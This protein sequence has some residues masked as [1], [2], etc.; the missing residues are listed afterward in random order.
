MASCASQTQRTEASSAPGGRPGTAG[1][2]VTYDAVCDRVEREFLDAGLLDRVQWPALRARGLEAA[3][4]CE[5]EAALGRVLDP[6]LAS[7]QVSHTRYLT[8]ADAAFYDLVDIFGLGPRFPELFPLGTVLIECTGLLT[9]RVAAGWVVLGVLSGSPAERAGVVVGDRVIRAD[10]RPF[11]PVASFTGKSGRSVS[12]AIERQGTAVVVDVTAVRM[13]PR[14]FL[15]ESTRA[16]M[17]T[18]EEE[19]V[20]VAY[21]RAWSYADERV[22]QAVAD[23]LASGP[24]SRC[25]ALILDLRGGW[26]GA[27]PEAL[28]LFNRAV[29]ELVMTDRTGQTRTLAARWRNPVVLLVDGRTRSG[30]E[31]IAH[32]F[33]EHGLGP[34]VGERTAGAVSGGAVFPTGRQSLLFLAVQRVRIDG[35]D[36]EGVGVQPDFVVP[37]NPELQGSTDPQLARA[38]G[39]AAALVRSDNVQGGSP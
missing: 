37:W 16:S 31:M 2:R 12:L 20:Q 22:N 19:G 14:E 28:D 27:S 8:A 9:E 23:A 32:A 25:A 24:L 33:R 5:D 29:P 39:L 6:M 18:L 30:K 35:H 3:I 15:F 10:G 26:G 7:L 13:S 1:A 17:R 38:L 34:V 11:D 36:L 4:A 21:I